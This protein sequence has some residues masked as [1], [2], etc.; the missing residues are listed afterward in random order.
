[1]VPNGAT[2]FI[3]SLSVTILLLGSGYIHDT[4]TKL[5]GLLYWISQGANLVL[6]LVSL[7]FVIIVMVMLMN[8]S[9]EHNIEKRR[10]TFKKIA[11]I[12]TASVLAGYI[13][14]CVIECVMFGV[15][16]S[17]ELAKEFLFCA[18]DIVIVWL[19]YSIKE[20]NSKKERFAF[21]VLPIISIFEILISD[22]ITLVH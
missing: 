12:V 4:S 19:V 11:V 9:I 3:S 8:N 2:S 21:T 18:I 17:F 1:M 14:N 13:L 22:I 7:V 5:P 16:N 20:S 10:N 6:S 15:Y